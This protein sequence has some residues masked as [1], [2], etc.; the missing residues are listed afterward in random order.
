M[1]TILRAGAALLLLA[2]CSGADKRFELLTAGISKDSVGKLMGVERP[3][4]VDPYLVGGKY[5]EVMYFRK[6]GVS[7]SLPDRKLSPLIL[8]DGTLVSWGWK[9]LDSLS[10]VTKIQVAPK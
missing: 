2:G 3:Q 10:E 8:A 4:R 7:D 1:K 9:A 6:P 5:I